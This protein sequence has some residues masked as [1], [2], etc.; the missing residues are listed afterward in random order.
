MGLRKWRNLLS[1]GWRLY[2]EIAAIG[3][4]PDWFNDRTSIPKVAGMSS[5]YGPT[6][7]SEKLQWASASTTSTAYDIIV[8]AFPVAWH[9]CWAVVEAAHR[10]ICAFVV[11]KRIGTEIFGLWKEEGFGRSQ[12]L[13]K[14][15]LL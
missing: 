2:V 10:C 11:D 7:W 14:P 12:A 9:I 6:L 8:E 15:H 1:I 4:L 5:S 3:V 13:P